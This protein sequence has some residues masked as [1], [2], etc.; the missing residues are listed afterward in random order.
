VASRGLHRGRSR[1]RSCRAPPG[2]NQ[3][4][5]PGLFADAAGYIMG[6]TPSSPGAVAPLIVSA[7]GGSVLG[8]QWRPRGGRRRGRP[9]RSPPPPVTGMTCGASE[10]H[11]VG[12]LIAPAERLG[13]PDLRVGLTLSSAATS[14]RSATTS[15]PVGPRLL[16]RTTLHLLRR[17]DVDKAFGDPESSLDRDDGP[18][19]RTAGHPRDADVGGAIAV[20]ECHAIS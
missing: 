4:D 17:C 8:G 3:G 15:G 1:S 16:V 14:G 13:G 6:G 7:A 11:P 20:C 2:R 9:A 10:N 18:A 19:D 5:S 12:P